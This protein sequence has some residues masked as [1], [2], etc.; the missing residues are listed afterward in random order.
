MTCSDRNRDSGASTVLPEVLRYFKS[1]IVHISKSIVEAVWSP[2]TV[3]V[4]LMER[5]SPERTAWQANLLV[6]PGDEMRSVIYHDS[7]AHRR[8]LQ[9]R[10][11]S[12]TVATDNSA[13]TYLYLHVYGP[14]LVSVLLYVHGE[15]RY[16]E[17]NRSY[18]CR[19]VTMIA[20]PIVA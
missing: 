12:L 4:E 19:N 14:I 1:M 10:A 15:P 5:S 16:R 3:G 6:L 13:K 7:V 11:L 18:S 8:D 20:K 17:T 9:N 2:V